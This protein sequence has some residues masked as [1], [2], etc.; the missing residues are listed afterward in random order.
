MGSWYRSRCGQ[1]G[2]GGLDVSLGTL[3]ILSEMTFDTLLGVLT[4]ELSSWGL[5]QPNEATGALDVLSWPCLP[6]F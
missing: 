5:W 4:L 2:L 3:S 1:G 6:L